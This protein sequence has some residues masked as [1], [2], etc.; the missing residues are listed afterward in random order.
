M[1]GKTIYAVSSG[2]YSDYRVNALF[3]T[4]KAAK[5]FIELVGKKDNWCDFND[6]EE[7]ELDPP[8]VDNLNSGLSVWLVEMRRDGTVERSHATDND[9]YDIEY[10][11]NPPD[12]WRKTK[13]P[14]FKG[15]P[16]VHDTLMVRAWAKDSDHAVKIA[17]EKRIQMIAEGKWK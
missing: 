6:I 9:A 15:K 11:S 16:D 7:Y 13:A 2:N 3:S 14:A 4:K 8:A 12:I 17:N 5:E 1:S 10:A